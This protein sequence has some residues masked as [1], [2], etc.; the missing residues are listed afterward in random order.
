MSA[1]V[2]ELTASTMPLL[3]LGRLVGVAVGITVVTTVAAGRLVGAGVVDMAKLL[4][5]PV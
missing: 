4:L 5:H 1:H 3:L 2:V